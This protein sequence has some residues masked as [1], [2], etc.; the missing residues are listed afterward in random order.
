M[1]PKTEVSCLAP[2][3]RSRSEALSATRVFAGRTAMPFPIEEIRSPRLAEIFAYWG[4]RRRGRRFPARADIDP[5]DFGVGIALISLVEVH[6]R[7][8]ADGTLRFRYRVWG[9]QHTAVTG[10]EMT[11]KW[12]D[13]YPDPERREMLRQSYHDV[14]AAAMPRLRRRE[15]LLGAR[16]RAYEALLMPLGADDAG[17]PDMLMIGVDYL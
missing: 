6:D 10:V 13:D 11:G 7:Q 8:R 4:G 1:F 3:I 15:L 12:L 2:A 14:V 16:L 5:L 17:A 9:Q